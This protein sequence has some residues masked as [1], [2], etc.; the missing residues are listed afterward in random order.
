MAFVSDQQAKE[1]EDTAIE[2]NMDVLIE[3]HDELELLRALKLKSRL[4][5]INN[6]NLKTFEV[7][8]TNTKNLASQIPSEYTLV[9]ESGIFFFFFF[10]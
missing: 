10:F 7:S 8:L 6:R 9:S 2:Y 1:L 3:V 4:I 5:G